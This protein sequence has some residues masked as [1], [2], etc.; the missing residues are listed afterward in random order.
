[1][2]ELTAC[3]RYPE[4]M[5]MVRVRRGEPC[6]ILGWSLNQAR[7]VTCFVKV[8]SDIESRLQY[9]KTRT[10][11][12]KTSSARRFDTHGHQQPHHQPAATFRH[13]DW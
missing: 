4:R 1:M 12:E 6:R 11:L 9:T 3:T 13:A 7:G 10:S 2:E 8:A 5:D